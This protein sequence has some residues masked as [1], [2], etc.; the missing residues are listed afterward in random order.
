MMT[1]R[2]GD[3]DPAFKNEDREPEQNEADLNVS[4]CSLSA[5]EDEDVTGPARV[6]RSRG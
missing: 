3:G 4:L 2:T 6:G 5:R 1:M